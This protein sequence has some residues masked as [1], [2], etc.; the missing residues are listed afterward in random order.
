MENFTVKQLT[1]SIYNDAE[2]KR[3]MKEVVWENR[4]QTVAVIAFFFFGVAT[5]T[6]ILKRVKKN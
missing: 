1:S 5:L 4:I 6:D 3:D 2:L